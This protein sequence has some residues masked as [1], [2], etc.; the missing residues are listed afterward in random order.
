[1]AVQVRALGS[2]SLAYCSLGLL[3]LALSL[4]HSLTRS[5]TLVVALAPR[6]APRGTLLESTTHSTPPPQPL[7]TAIQ[8][9]QRKN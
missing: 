8:V 1:M 7:T 2:R 5:L 3:S 9:T 4:S 6:V